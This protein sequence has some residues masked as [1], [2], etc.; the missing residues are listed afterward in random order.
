M[1]LERRPELFRLNA[2]PHRK[3]DVVFAVQE[4]GCCSNRSSGY[5]FGD[6]DNSSAVFTT[7][8]VPNVEAQIYLVEISMKWNWEI[9]KHLGTKKSE[10]H[11]AKICLSLE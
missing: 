3:T 6:K 2:A 4:A 1:V 11:E 9:A 7:L 5:N 10:T 8:F